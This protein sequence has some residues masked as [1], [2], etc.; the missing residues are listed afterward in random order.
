[1]EF[2]SCRGLK[3]LRGV[4]KNIRFLLLVF[5]IFLFG[6]ASSG[7][8]IKEE[9]ILNQYAYVTGRYLVSWQ[10]LGFSQVGGEGDTFSISNSDSYGII[11]A[12]PG[13]Y[14]VT[15]AALS[16][17]SSL[18]GSKDRPLAVVYLEPGKITYIG[19]MFFRTNAS[20]LAAIPAGVPGF[21]Q[22]AGGS[23]RVAAM[24]HTKDNTKAVKEAILKEHPELAQK[25]NALFV[26][27]PAK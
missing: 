16:S 15:Y 27:K 5:V 20:R 23:Q 24:M 7:Q 9:G 18:M 1:M 22:G 12:R 2:Q 21:P 19:D 25:L 4:M 26:Y 3:R 6:C 17:N 10:N 8:I 13:R 11:K 14:I